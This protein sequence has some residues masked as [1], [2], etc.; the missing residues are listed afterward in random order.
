M[1]DEKTQQTDSDLSG[2]RK[3]ATFLLAFDSDT[4]G[5]IMRHLDDRDLGMLSEEMTRLGDVTAENVDKVLK[6]FDQ[7]GESIAVEPMLVE[8]LEK[9]LGHEKAKALLERIRKRSITRE[10]FRA[11]RR[12]SLHQLRSVLAGEHPQVLALV[13]S[14]LDSQMA[15]DLL[16][17]MDENLRYDVVRRIVCTEE[18]PFEMVQQI[19]AILEARA[20]EAASEKTVGERN[21]FQTVAHMLNFAEPGLSKSIMER[22][23]KD[24]PEAAGEIQALMFVFDD[25]VLIGDREMQ[26]VLGELDKE[27]LALALKTATP[28]V[29]EKLMGNLSKRARDNLQDEM[30]MLGPKPLSEVEEAQKRIVEHVREL[31][32]RGEITINRGG[33][34]EMV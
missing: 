8:M 32:E 23:N 26:K 29:T 24:L 15:F 1:P 4:A 31:E 19:D 25:L 22:L 12:L 21:R 11:L 16:R 18:M 2:L 9:A 34:E 17:E 7:A 33:A 10:P 27:D 13:V 20:V 28:E 3:A 6:E 5:A 30:E 14:Y